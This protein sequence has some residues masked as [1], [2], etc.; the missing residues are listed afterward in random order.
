MYTHDGQQYKWI[1]YKPRFLKSLLNVI[2]MLL[3]AIIFLHNYQTHLSL[4][5]SKVK[6]VNILYTDTNFLCYFLILLQ[7]LY[8]L[9]PLS[10]TLGFL[11]D[12]LY[13][14]YCS[15]LVFIM[16][17]T[18]FPPSVLILSSYLVSVSC[19]NTNNRT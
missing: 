16:V 4:Q 12:I 14:C 5:G 19:R 9:F 10:F 1:E 18:P 17:P 2:L 7:Y 3:S 11:T 8:I 15:Q 13:S 6:T